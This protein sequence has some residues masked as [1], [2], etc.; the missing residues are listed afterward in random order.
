[1][2]ANAAVVLD[3]WEW[4]FKNGEICFKKKKTLKVAARKVKRFQ[5]AGRLF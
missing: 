2:L 4:E 5:M 1:M 3:S